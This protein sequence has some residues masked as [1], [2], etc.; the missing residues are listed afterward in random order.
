MS[1]EPP[2]AC[3][4]SASDF[5]ARRGTLSSGILTKATQVD[6][7]PD[8]LEWH[9]AADDDSVRAL[10]ALI[11]A[12]RRCCRFLRFILSV[13][14]GVSEVTLEVTGPPGTREFLDTWIAQR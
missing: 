1:I 5:A 2:I 14:P 9:F 13:E 6:E 10:A 4:L 7:V 3:S 8:G 11:D 12:E